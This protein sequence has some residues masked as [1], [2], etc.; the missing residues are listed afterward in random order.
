MLQ[1]EPDG[2]GGR[3]RAVRVGVGANR[4]TA[5]PGMPAA[6]DNQRLG[7]GDAVKVR[8][9]EVTLLNWYT[10]PLVAWLLPSPMPRDEPV[11]RFYQPTSIRA[12]ASAAAAIRFP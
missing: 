6:V 7:H 2:L 10:F 1:E 5:V 9:G 12:R 3:V 11:N 4:A 8:F